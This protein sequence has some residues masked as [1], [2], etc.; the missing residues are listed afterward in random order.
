MSDGRPKPAIPAWQRAAPKPPPTEDPVS[1]QPE[2]AQT[3]K[4]DAT[5]SDSASQ[6]TDV[7]AEKPEPESV[8]S[9]DTSPTTAPTAE[10]VEPKQAFET[11]D[12]ESFRQH[13]QQPI[14]TS[15]PPQEAPQR[16]SAPPII[17]YPEFLVE[18]HKPPPLITPTRILN[19]V[20]V[21]GGIA[22]LLYGAS[23]WIINPMVDT[24]SDSRHDFL[25]HSQTKV[26]EMNERLEKLVSKLPE[27]KKETSE[28]DDE[29][30]S[31][32]SDPT[33]LY[34]RDMGTQTSP[35][36][37]RRSSLPGAPEQKKPVDYQ[38]G[39]LEIMR[40]HLTELADGAEQAE[41][42][43]KERQD[44]MNKL[45][46]Y[47]DGLIYGGPTLNA[48]QTSEDAITMKN[49]ASDD[50]IEELKKEIRGVKGVLLSAKRFPAVSRPVAG[51]A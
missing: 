28:Q 4:A 35:L 15:R 20:Y 43:S 6:E 37:S 31:V 33:E 49:G 16:P 2:A 22:A 50:A 32:T 19:S 10:A 25:S 48:W 30:E 1:S 12:F 27:P 26:D 13:Q 41:E 11:T 46:H 8:P 23:K 21:A 44:K 9:D 29:E 24:L 45:R 17:T 36:P 38:T 3:E 18:A 5:T 40:S 42:G 39:A 47:L 34:H 7:T 51:A 14:Q